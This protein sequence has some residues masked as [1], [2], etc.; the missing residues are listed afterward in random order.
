MA[1]PSFPRVLRSRIARA[2]VA[3]V[4]MTGLVAATPT[5][6][7]AVMAPPDFETCLLNKINQARANAGQAPL[8]MATDINEGARGWSLWMSEHTFRHTTTAE[9]L[10]IL[11]DGTFTHGENIAWRRDH[12]QTDCTEIHQMFMGSSGHKANIL[13]SQWNFVALGAYYAGNNE[14]WVTEM[15]FDAHGY[16]PAPAA[17]ETGQRP[18]PSGGCDSLAVVNNGG[19]WRLYNKLSPDSAKQD[20]YFGNPGDIPFMGDWDGDGVATPGLYRQSDGFVYLRNSNTQGIADITFYFGNPG[21]IPLVGDFNGNGKDTVSIYRSSEA[22]VYVINK[23]GKNGGGLGAAD[24]SF[25]FGKP[26]DSPF[27]G[28]FNGNGK[29]TVG[30]HRASTGFVYYRNTL[31]Q[32]YA[33][34]SFFFGNPGDVILT[35]DWDKDGD[36]TVAAYR[37][38]SGRIYVNLQNNAGEADY[39]LYVGPYPVAATFGLG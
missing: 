10:A 5:P 2:L 20:F 29:D 17:V 18:C 12:N 19:M 14:W 25:Y 13:R 32:G 15:F 38:S 7:T 21:D 35:G 22:K 27:V 28:D 39:S 11:P 6:A 34:K 30:L 9:R 23:L 8:V 37:P 36:D 31:T 16:S 3:A 24:Y 33:D 4:L 1:T 26:G